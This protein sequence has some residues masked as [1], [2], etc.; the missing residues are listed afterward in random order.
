MFT[1]GEINKKT[2]VQSALSVIFLVIAFFLVYNNFIKSPEPFDTAFKEDQGGESTKD[3]DK[4]NVDIFDNSV[5]KNLTEPKEL[6]F[7]EKDE[8]GR[9]NPFV[10]F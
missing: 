3:L 4:F 6:T 7:P 10:K 1:F 8:I 9:G 2:I 5:F